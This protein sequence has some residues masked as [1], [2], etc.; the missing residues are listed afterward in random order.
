M[1]MRCEPKVKPTLN[2]KPRPSTGCAGPRTVAGSLS[3]VRISILNTRSL[4]GSCSELSGTVTHEAGHAFGLADFP[5]DAYTD[6][7][8]EMTVMDYQ[9]SP[10]CTPT[11]FDVAA[12]KAIHQSQP[13][14]EQGS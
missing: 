6:S 14:P 4:L 11:P 1:L 9:F 13:Q 10:D 8:V 12:V 2:S 3:Y 7:H 5:R